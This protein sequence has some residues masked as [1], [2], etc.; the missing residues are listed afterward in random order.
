VTITLTNSCATTTI[1]PFPFVSPY[2]YYI[3]DDEMD[4]LF[5]E[6][7]QTTVACGSLTYTGSYYITAG[8]TTTM[9]TSFHSGNIM[10]VNNTL[11]Y[12]LS[13]YSTDDS[14][15][16]LYTVILAGTN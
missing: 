1:V 15:V 5:D 9:D 14:D 16:G 10:L 12:A 13:V 6:W 7:V 4:I 11:A 8:S 2:T 3:G